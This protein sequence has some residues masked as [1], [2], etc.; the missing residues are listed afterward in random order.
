MS[1][2]RLLM[3]TGGLSIPGAITGHLYDAAKKKKESGKSYR[4]CLKESVK[5]TVCEDMPGTSHIYKAGHKDG[6]LEG[7]CEQAQRD[8]RKME[9][10]RNAHETDRKR[11]ETIDKE[12]DILLD[13]AERRFNDENN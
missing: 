9:S 7:T 10:M 12:K 1:L 11:W 3:K 2:K 6:K 8:E 5:E 4:E 13:E